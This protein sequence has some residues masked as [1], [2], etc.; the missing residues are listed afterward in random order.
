MKSELKPHGLYEATTSW[1]NA[2]P[3]AESAKLK[4]LGT[5]TVLNI[6]LFNK[7]QEIEE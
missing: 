6:I 3:E 1:D 5:R 2:Y 4:W 7:F